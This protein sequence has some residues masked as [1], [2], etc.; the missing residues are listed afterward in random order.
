MSGIEIIGI[1]QFKNSAKAEDPDL[2][3]TKLVLS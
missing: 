3:I 1:L 2:V